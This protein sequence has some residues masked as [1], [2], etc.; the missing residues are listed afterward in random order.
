MILFFIAVFIFACF[1]EA[2][3]KDEQILEE[4]R[5]KR[6][7]EIEK[8]YRKEIAEMNRIANEEHRKVHKTQRRFA[9]DKEG[10]VLGEEIKEEV[11]YE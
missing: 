7:R 9:M 11:F 4:K 1:V 8:E 5:D 3:A 6:Y 2:S 10:N